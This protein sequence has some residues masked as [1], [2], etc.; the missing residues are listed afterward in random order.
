MA[1]ATSCFPVESSTGNLYWFEGNHSTVLSSNS[2]G[3]KKNLICCDNSHF[4]TCLFN[5]SIHLALSCQGRTSNLFLIP[6]THPTPL[7]K[8]SRPKFKNS[9]KIRLKLLFGFVVYNVKLIT[10]QKWTLMR[11]EHT[12]PYRAKCYVPVHQIHIL[13]LLLWEEERQNN[14]NNIWKLL[15]EKNGKERKG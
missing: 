10:F 12:S 4:L 6:L 13:I 11:T 14:F 8:L 3:K 2:H 5:L 9:L 7:A 15:V 1:S